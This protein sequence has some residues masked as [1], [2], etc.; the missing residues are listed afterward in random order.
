VGHLKLQGCTILQPYLQVL[1]LA[2]DKRSSLFLSYVSDEG[3]SFITF[4]L[5]LIYECVSD[6][7]K[8]P[9]IFLNFFHFH[10]LKKSLNIDTKF[11]RKSFGR[12]TI[13]RKTF[14]RQSYHPLITSLFLH[15]GCVIKNLWSY[16]AVCYATNHSI[17]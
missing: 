10:L 7:F 13:D 9:V 5:C 3:T 12:K 16:S 2:K 14:V 11:S 4:S 6:F 15:L 8:V 17:I 1:K